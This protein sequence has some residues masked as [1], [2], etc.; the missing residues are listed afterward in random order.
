MHRPLL[1][2]RNQRQSNYKPIIH[3]GI[4]KKKKETLT[5]EY[6]DT[7]QNFVLFI[8]AAADQSCF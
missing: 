7:R 5:N 1:S 3:I 2:V 8:Y 4:E 6:Y